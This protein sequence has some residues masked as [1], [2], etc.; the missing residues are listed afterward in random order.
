MPD[1]PEEG[2]QL[3]VRVERGA[4]Q[5]ACFSGGRYVDAYGLPLDASRIVEW[6]PCTPVPRSVPG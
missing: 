5:T 1:H 2:Q 6:Q 3:E 4:W